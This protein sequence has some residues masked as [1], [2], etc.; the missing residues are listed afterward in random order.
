MFQASCD[1]TRVMSELSVETI[2]KVMLLPTREINKAFEK[3]LSI[4]I[5]KVIPQNASMWDKIEAHWKAKKKLEA[6]TI[7]RYACP[8]C[9]LKDCKNAVEEE[10]VRR[11]YKRYNED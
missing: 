2:N 7:F 11:G 6:I 8:Q 4:A 9:N 10:M 5:L 3:A 1:L